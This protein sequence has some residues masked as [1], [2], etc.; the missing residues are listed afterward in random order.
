[1]TWEHACEKEICLLQSRRDDASHELSQLSAIQ[2]G[3]TYVLQGINLGDSDGMDW[4]RFLFTMIFL[5][6][7]ET[8]ATA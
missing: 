7:T 1:M 4:V 8:R 3:M 2:Q 5:D 6:V